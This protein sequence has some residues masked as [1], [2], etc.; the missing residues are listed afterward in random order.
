MLLTALQGKLAK[1]SAIEG[2]QSRLP[3]LRDLT[4]ILSAWRMIDINAHQERSI[5]F[6]ALPVSAS[7]NLSPGSSSHRMSSWQQVVAIT[8]L[9]VTVAVMVTVAKAVEVV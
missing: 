7:H 9:I 4:N 8:L 6:Q 3:K 1:P 5:P 2:E